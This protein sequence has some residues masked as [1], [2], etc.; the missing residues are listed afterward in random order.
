MLLLIEVKLDSSVFLQWLVL[1]NMIINNTYDSSLHPHIVL[2][3]RSFV[4]Y[5][6]TVHFIRDISVGTHITSTLS[7]IVLLYEWCMK[8]VYDTTHFRLSAM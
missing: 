1:L 4:S 7:G 8:W 2:R 3:Q 6:S 5:L